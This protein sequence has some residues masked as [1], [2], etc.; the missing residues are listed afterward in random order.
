MVLTVL[1]HLHV[2]DYVKSSTSLMGRIFSAADLN[3][4][5]RGFAHEEATRLLRIQA[6]CTFRKFYVLS[7]SRVA[8]SAA[9]LTALPRLIKP[10]ALPCVGA[11]AALHWLTRW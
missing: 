3:F 10:L 1:D 2:L 6:R 5:H 11:P 7:V 4:R 8:T 9:L